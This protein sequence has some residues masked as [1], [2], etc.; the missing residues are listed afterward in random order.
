MQFVRIFIGVERIKK[1]YDAYLHWIKALAAEL[2]MRDAIMGEKVGF[3]RFALS[4]NVLEIKIDCCLRVS[5][6]CPC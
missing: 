2:E 5:R 6:K 3:V 1:K 4:V